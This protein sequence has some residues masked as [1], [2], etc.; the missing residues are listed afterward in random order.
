MS[1]IG[2]IKEPNFLIPNTKKIFNHLRLIFIKASI[3]QY[4]IEKVIS[5]FKL[6]YQIIT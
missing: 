1:K 4:L 2:A 3:F 5:G 6:I